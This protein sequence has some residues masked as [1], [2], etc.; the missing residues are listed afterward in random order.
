MIKICPYGASS[1]PPEE[2][3]AEWSALLY[4]MSFIVKSRVFLALLSGS[5]SLIKM[6][7]NL[8]Q[9]WL[10]NKADGEVTGGSGEQV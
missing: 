5:Y 4:Y 6:N 10:I 9:M 1:R 8:S 3:H 7:F 2:L